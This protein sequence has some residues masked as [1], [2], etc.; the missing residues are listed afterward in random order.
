MKVTIMRA[1]RGEYPSMETY[2]DGLAAGLREAFPD[3]EIAEVEPKQLPN[4]GLL[5]KPARAINGVRRY[6]ER[7][8]SYPRRALAT[9]PD[10]I[11]V[12]SDHYFQVA[13]F[14]RPGVKVVATC[15]DLI[16]YRFRKN[17]EQFAAFVGVS[18]TAQEFSM[19][20]LRRCDHVITLSQDNVNDLNSILG[21]PRERMTIIHNAVPAHF[22][23]ATTESRAAARKAL[24]LADTTFAIMHVGTVEPRKNVDAILETMGLLKNDDVLFLKAG[25]EFTPAQNARIAALGIGPRIRHLGR[26]ANEK[27]VAIYHASDALVFP[28]LYEGFPFPIVEAMASGTPVITSTASSLPETA[29]GAAWLADPHDYPTIAAAIRR[30]RDESGLRA[31]RTAAGFARVKDLTWKKNAEAVATVYQNLFA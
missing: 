10:V 26:I 30:L 18:R 27:M 9:K 22:V 6:I 4:S 12:I 17:I 25:I 13:R 19:R 28:S 5:S 1:M 21:V 24:G 29:G 15:H 3:W 8:W 20:S 16:Y 31:E 14:H 7:F 11:H 2:A 23:P